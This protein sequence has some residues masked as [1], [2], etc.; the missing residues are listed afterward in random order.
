MRIF[1]TDS[2]KA[3]KANAF[4]YINAIHYLAPMTIAGAGNVCGNESAGC[5]A[6]C[7]GWFSGQA[8]MVRD[9]DHDSN[10][11]RASRV[12]KT[13]AFMH[14]RVNYLR[15]MVREI[16]K[17]ARKA[18]RDGR[19]LCVRLNG[20][21]DIA[22]EAIRF[23]AASG[24]KNLFELFPCVAFV[25][26]TK[27]PRRF[28]R[29]LPANYRLTF[30]RSETNEAECI[31]LLVAGHNVA[32]VFAGEKPAKWNGFVV[33]DGDRHDLR[34]LDPNGVV[35]ALTPKGRRAKNDTSGFVVR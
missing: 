27:N 31:P 17:L 7:L 5:A 29:K 33:I 15:A 11:T 30:S 24:G 3:I 16:D 18:Q 2:P 28:A 10:S 34:H 23:P 4:G 13:R 9:L 1:S 32:I 25:D 14:D 6:L 12:A 19:K 8:S 21:S 20:S 22:W 35:V 26:Y